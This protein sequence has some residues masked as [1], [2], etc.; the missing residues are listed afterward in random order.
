MKVCDDYRLTVQVCGEDHCGRRAE[1]VLYVVG[2]LTEPLHV[3]GDHL[4]GDHP[5]PVHGLGVLDER[6]DLFETGLERLF[7]LKLSGVMR[8]LSQPGDGVRY[9]SDFDA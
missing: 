3:G 2:D 4:P 6:A 5:G 9:L 7:T 8:F 1:P